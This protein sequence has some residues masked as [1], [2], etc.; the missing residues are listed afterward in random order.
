MKNNNPYTFENGGRE[1]SFFCMKLVDFL[2]REKREKQLNSEQFQSLWA[3][4][5]D[6]AKSGGCY[7]RPTC[8]I[9]TRTSKIGVQLRLF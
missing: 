8:D 7:Y 6:E 3:V 2:S 5:F 9:Y 4:R 1:N